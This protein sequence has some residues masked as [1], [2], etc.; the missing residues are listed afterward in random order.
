MP[1]FL[2]VIFACCCG[3]ALAAE[4]LQLVPMRVERAGGGAVRIERVE[5]ELTPADPSLGETDDAG[6]RL[7]IER[8]PERSC[9]GTPVQA[10]DE[11]L[12]PRLLAVVGWSPRAAR[13]WDDF[14]QSAR[15]GK[16]HREK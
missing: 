14:D 1:R 16:E 10:C 3:S 11:S 12:W 6:G 15:I 7:E 8:Y 2:A 13:D 9:G 4:P 5:T